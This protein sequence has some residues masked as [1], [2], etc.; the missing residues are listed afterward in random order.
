[1]KIKKKKVEKKCVRKRKLK[2]RDYQICL[3]TERER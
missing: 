1:M 2:L 3:E